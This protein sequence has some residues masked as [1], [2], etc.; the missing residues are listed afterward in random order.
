MEA[1]RM[2]LTEEV[3]RRNLQREKETTRAKDREE[4]TGEEMGRP[5]ERSTLAE[6]DSPGEKESPGRVGRTI[7]RKGHT[8]R[9]TEQGKG[10]TYRITGGLPAPLVAEAA[11]QWQHHL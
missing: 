9:S 8:A 11:Q 4:E 2:I 6:T 10:E 3:S 5:R 1:W 7:A